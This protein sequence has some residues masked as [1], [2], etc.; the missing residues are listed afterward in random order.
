MGYAIRTDRYR[1]VEWV[2]RKTG[3]TDAEELYDHQN[4][5][6]ENT[7]ILSREEAH[8]LVPDLRKQLWQAL[9]RPALQTPADNNNNNK[10]PANPSKLPHEPYDDT[11]DRSP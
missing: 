8:S 1:Y 2:N 6:G 7:N 4:D 9:G 3:R 11:P 10:K 5:P